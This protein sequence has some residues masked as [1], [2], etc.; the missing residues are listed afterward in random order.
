MLIEGSSVAIKNYV[1][2]IK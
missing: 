1:C 2:V